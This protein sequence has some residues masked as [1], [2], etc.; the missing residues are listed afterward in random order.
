MCPRRM[1]PRLL[2]PHLFRSIFASALLACLGTGSVSAQAQT[3]TPS[4]KV[5]IAQ[6]LTGPF[7]PSSWCRTWPATRIARASW[8]SA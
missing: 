1:R 4:V 5:G 2:R 6:D 7:A 3:V 8:W